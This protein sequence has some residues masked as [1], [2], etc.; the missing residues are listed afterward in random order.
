MHASSFLLN[1][2]FTSTGHLETEYGTDTVIEDEAATQQRYPGPKR[3]RLKKE[4]AINMKH[5]I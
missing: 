2:F 3:V 1:C 4:I 5:Y